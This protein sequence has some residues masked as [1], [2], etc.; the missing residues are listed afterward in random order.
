MVSQE[1]KMDRVVADLAPPPYHPLSSNIIFK[2]TIHLGQKPDWRV[3]KD[4]FFREGTITKSDALK[5][6]HQAELIF[7][8]EDNLMQLSDP[9]TVVGD[10][11]GQY[12]DMMKLLDLGGSPEKTKYLF[13]GDYVDRGMF[14]IEVILLLYSLKINYPST[15]YMIRGNHECRQMTSMFSFR[16]ECI[17]KYDLEVYE[18]FMDSFDCLPMACI[19]NGSFLA[20]HGGLSPELVSIRD[21]ETMDRFTEPARA[22]LQCD[23]LWSDPIDIPDGRLPEVYRNNETR[24]CSYFFGGEAC[25]KFLKD[26]D[27][28]SVIRAHE[29]QKD[30]YKMLFWNGTDFPSTITIFSAPNYCDCYKNKGAIIKFDNST[31]NIQQY[32]YSKHPYVLPD[33]MDVFAWSIPFVIEKVIKML[34]SVIKPQGK[35][36]TSFDEQSKARLKELEENVS[37][38]NEFNTETVEKIISHIRAIREKNEMIIR[39]ETFNDGHAEVVPITNP[40][41]P[42]LED[43]TE[44]FMNAIMRDRVNEKRPEL[45]NIR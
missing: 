9:V 2:G 4:H 21:L 11:H 17:Y 6:I 25:R 22:G 37:K 13:L 35:Y 16:R 20:V 45:T 29:A 23:L 30:G 42:K 12:Y 38:S 39:G 36:F 31:L 26:N 28:V 24:G 41:R 10:I 8:K 27:L 33:F 34:I 1:V 43:D 14:S 32:N 5:I 18:S 3:L 40:L 15:I 44:S 19:L 7:K